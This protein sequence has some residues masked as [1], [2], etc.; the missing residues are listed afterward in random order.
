MKIRSTL[1]LAIGGLF[2][3]QLF[4]SCNTTFDIT[5]RRYNKGFFIDVSSN[6][7]KKSESKTVAVNTIAPVEKTTPVAPAQLSVTENIAA[8]I[9]EQQSVNTLT[10]STDNKI[11]ASVSPRMARKINKALATYA[12]NE[13]QVEKIASASVTEASKDAKDVKATK[14]HKAG[15]KSQLVAVLLAF[16]LGGL[17]IHRFYLGYTWQGVVQ[18]LTLGGCGVWALIDFIRILIGDL[19]PKDGNYDK[20]L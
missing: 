13:A 1:I 15:S 7:V 19:G 6:E 4:S 3:A 9:K 18:L 12:M 11:A 5:K 14:S 10:A 2:I 17:G 20:T 8:S 16:F